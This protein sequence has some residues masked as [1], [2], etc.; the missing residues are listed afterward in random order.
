MRDGLFRPKILQ[1]VE[2]LP[3]IIGLVLDQSDF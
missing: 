1:V 3:K 2:N